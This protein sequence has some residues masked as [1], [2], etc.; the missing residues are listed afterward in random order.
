MPNNQQVFERDDK[1]RKLF[2]KYE[3]CGD[4]EDDGYDIRDLI[5]C[6]EVEDEELEDL[7]G[8]EEEALE[9]C[10][11]SDDFKEN[12]NRE[13]VVYNNTPKTLQDLERIYEPDFIQ[14]LKRAFNK[15]CAELDGM[16]LLFWKR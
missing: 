13:L 6:G 1:W 8:V 2:E 16:N 10:D 12:K 5:A 9:S 15:R 7:F 4:C 3:N 11:D 14:G